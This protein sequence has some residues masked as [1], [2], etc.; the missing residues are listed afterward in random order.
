MEL[1]SLGSNLPFTD[2]VTFRKLCN[3]SVIFVCV[4]ELVQEY[5]ENR[6]YIIHAEHLELLT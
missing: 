4:C 1:D 3:L 2:Y 5:N 6:R